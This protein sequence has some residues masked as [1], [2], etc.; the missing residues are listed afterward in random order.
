VRNLTSPAES[1]CAEANEPPLHLRRKK[2][3]LQFAARLLSNKSNPTYNTV[4]DPRYKELFSNGGK[5]FIPPFGIRIKQD[6][7]SINFD[8]L[9]Q[10][11]NICLD[12]CDSKKSETDPLIIKAKFFEVKHSCGRYM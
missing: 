12:L 9:L 6:F 2:L 8:W 4:F 3:F 7:D 10:Q 1:L 5:T 11:V